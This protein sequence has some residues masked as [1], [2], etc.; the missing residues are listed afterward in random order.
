MNKQKCSFL[1]FVRIFLMPLVNCVQ[2]AAGLKRLEK[3]YENRY[4]HFY[5][6]RSEASNGIIIIKN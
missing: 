1:Y 4:K 6:N 3:K 5:M 2:Y